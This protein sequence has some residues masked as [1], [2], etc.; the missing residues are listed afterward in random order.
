MKNYVKYT[1]EMDKTAAYPAYL[2][3]TN[4]LRQIMKYQ[5]DMEYYMD[6]M[7]DRVAAGML[8]SGV[9]KEIEDSLARCI[10]QL[11]HLDTETRNYVSAYERYYFGKNKLEDTV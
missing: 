11:Q 6:V 10:N 4:S 3:I 5:L 2:E 9:C 8:C 1:Q 7:E